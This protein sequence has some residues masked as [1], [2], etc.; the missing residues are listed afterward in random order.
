MQKISSIDQ[1]ILWD[2]AN[3]SYDLKGHDQISPCY[4]TTIKK[5]SDFSELVL[6]RKKSAQSIK[7]FLRYRF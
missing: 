1:F 4:P 7:S 3:E 2:K 6:A 5:T